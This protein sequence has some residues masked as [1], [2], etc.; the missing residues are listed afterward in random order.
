MPQSI[1]APSAKMVFNEPTSEL[2]YL[3]LII[4]IKSPDLAHE[5]Y[6]QT[7]KMIEDIGHKATYEQVCGTY[8]VVNIFRLL[9]LL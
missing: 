6:Q 3:A 1:P 8:I 7:R 2:Q 4:L 9:Q 5:V